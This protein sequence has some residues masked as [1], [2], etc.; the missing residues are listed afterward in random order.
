[1][2]AD[3]VSTA[4]SP[5][6]WVAVALYS[7]SSVFYV[8]AFVK[9]PAWMARAARW[10]LFAAFL[11][12]GTDIGWRGVQ[13][14]HPGTS[15]REALGFLAWVMV[16]GY[17]LWRRR[18]KL[19]VVGAFLAPAAMVILVAA[20]LSPSGSAVTQL[21][22]LGRIHISLATL[23]VA[24]FALAASVSFVYLLQERNLKGKKF[25]RVLFRRG[26]AL[27]S[28]DTLAHRLIVVGFPIFTLSLM[29]GVI[30]IAQR[31]GGTLARPEYPFALVT[32]LCYGVLLVA[33][34]T[35]GWRGRKA[36]ILTVVG[37]A[38]A[39]L[40]LGIYFARRSM[41]IG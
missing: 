18:L 13:G 1:M 21:T 39:L 17:L 2:T 37:F 16:G 3:L 7:I 19:S 23:G 41:G 35:R 24:I 25:D 22:T 28:L 15:V 32:W 4:P 34:T 38:A 29:L 27:E 8:S 11:A 6:F 31:S 30:W 14:V 12:H 40:V 10:G 26:V 5:A 20:R 36:A 9:A 33:R